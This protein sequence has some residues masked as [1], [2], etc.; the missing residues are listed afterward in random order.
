VTATVIALPIVPRIEASG[1]DEVTLPVRLPRRAF[2]RLTTLAA[3]WDVSLNA[4]AALML[5][6]A[7][8]KRAGVK[9]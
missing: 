8:N 3:Q 7:I 6:E 1:A 5:T 4:A 2:G 9:R